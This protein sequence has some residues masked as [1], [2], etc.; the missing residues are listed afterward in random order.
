MRMKEEIELF[1]LEDAPTK[2]ISAA[3]E[4]LEL[5]Q[6]ADEMYYHATLERCAKNILPLFR[7][8]TGEGNAPYLWAEAFDGNTQ[9]LLSD[10]NHSAL[11]VLSASPQSKHRDV[12]LPFFE[13]LAKADL[14]NPNNKPAEEEVALSN[15]PQLN[16]DYHLDARKFP[17]ALF[18][19]LLIP[20]A[21]F[22]S[23]STLFLYTVLTQHFIFP[24]N[25]GISIVV[26]LLC[27]GLSFGAIG[28][29][30]QKSNKDI[31]TSLKAIRFVIAIPLLLLAA[32]TGYFEAGISTAFIISIAAFLAICI[33]IAALLGKTKNSSQE[34]GK[35]DLFTKK[36]ALPLL[37]AL[38]IAAFFFTCCVGVNTFFFNSLA[39]TLA[40]PLK[41]TLFFTL[42]SIVSFLGALAISYYMQDIR[43][44]KNKKQ[45]QGHKQ[46]KDFVQ[47]PSSELGPQWISLSSLGEKKQAE[48]QKEEK[49]TKPLKEALEIKLHVSRRIKSIAPAL[50]AKKKSPV[51][52]KSRESDTLGKLT[53]AGEMLAQA[54]FIFACIIALSEESVFNQLYFG[55][56][57]N[58]VDGFGSFPLIYKNTRHLIQKTDQKSNTKKTEKALISSIIIVEST[59]AFF[60]IISTILYSIDDKK[61]NQL[62]NWAFAY[63]MFGYSLSTLKD[64]I[65]AKKSCNMESVLKNK[66]VEFRALKKGEKFQHATLKKEILALARV[67]HEEG[68]ITEIELIDAFG[69][70]WN[71]F[72]K[73]AQDTPS[74]EEKNSVKELRR[75]NEEEYRL[76]CVSFLGFLLEMVSFIM[77]AADLPLIDAKNGG[78]IPFILSAAIKA[79]QFLSNVSERLSLLSIDVAEQRN[80]LLTEISEL[81]IDKQDLDAKFNAILLELKVTK[82]D[83]IKYK[84]AYA[85]RKEEV[86]EDSKEIKTFLEHLHSSPAQLDTAVDTFVCAMQNTASKTDFQD[87]DEKNL[88][89]FTIEKL[90]NEPG[91]GNEVPLFDTAQKRAEETYKQICKEKKA[92]Q[93]NG[94]YTFFFPQK[95]ASKAQKE[96]ALLCI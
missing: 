31:H 80:F 65:E 83:I 46:Q 35:L 90:L 84:I 27:G 23:V 55:A 64:I 26:A 38:P 47:P 72:K 51:Y 58:F 34:K 69:S 40:N 81:S 11:L 21:L 67:L 93:Y 4:V 74:Q 9:D 86:T 70:S 91:K 36:L 82:E 44:P 61:Y 50:P 89:Q 53:T 20:G 88:A 75:I 66:L 60:S 22:L 3:K 87:Q 73:D 39:S 85:L 15:P 63:S 71:A 78:L 5:E 79:I 59:A 14:K 96:P 62:S 41:T 57:W 68:E 33:P 54:Y 29:Y 52:F 25:E 45:N 28:T 32:Y 16:R 1:F 94:R 42:S 30:A 10:K 56:L 17:R 37:R 12:L 13:L 76:S 49:E 43:A 19:W 77:F 48:E 92:K 2:A 18:Y 95:G 7:K 8:E 6:D 24:F